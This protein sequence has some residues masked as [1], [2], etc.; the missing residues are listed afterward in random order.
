MGT[1]L[2]ERL[3][4][5]KALPGR[6]DKDPGLIAQ[7]G[8]QEDPFNTEQTAALGYL[9]TQAVFSD[10]Y[11]RTIEDPM[12]A[13]GPKFFG[14]TWT[15]LGLAEMALKACIFDR[16]LKKGK[17]AENAEKKMPAMTFVMGHTH[18]PVLQVVKVVR[19]TPPK[20][21][22]DWHTSVEIEP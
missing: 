16:V 5:R 17:Q 22:A 18:E 15:R 14:G 2:D 10:N 12:G 1:L 4:G 8:H 13:I 21:P 9:L 19:P 3:H 20:E 11:I 6:F 7:H